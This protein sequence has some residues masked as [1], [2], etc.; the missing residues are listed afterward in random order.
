M[1]TK[2]M[3]SEDGKMVLCCDEFEMNLA[4]KRG[5]TTETSFLEYFQTKDEEL[6]AQVKIC[7]EDEDGYYYENG[8][9]DAMEVMYKA[10]R[11]FDFR[12]YDAFYRLMMN[13]ENYDDAKGMSELMEQCKT[14]VKAMIERMKGLEELFETFEDLFKD[15]AINSE[16]LA[17][18]LEE[19]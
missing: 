16:D 4:K 9:Y 8:S 5:Y 7:A 14:E 15:I 3:K 18:E 12:H 1:E 6:K 10:N 11:D 13:W 2:I 17:S 19:N